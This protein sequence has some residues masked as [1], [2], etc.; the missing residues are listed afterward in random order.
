MLS[1]KVPKSPITSED[2]LLA[3]ITLRS[4]DGIGNRRIMELVEAFEK[5]TD[6]FKAPAREIENVL[7]PKSVRKDIVFDVSRQRYSSL[8]IGKSISSLK[9]DFSVARKVLDDLSKCD[10]RVI[11]YW[12]EEYLHRL[13]TI[14]DTPVLLYAA[15]VPSKL[16][17]YSIAIVGTRTPSDYSKLI[18][19][20]I[21]HSLAKQGI[22]VVS[23]MAMGIDS[24]A[25]E[26][27]LSAGGRT[28]GVLGTGIDI[29]YPSSNKRIFELVKKQGLLLSEYPPKT[30]PETYHFPQRNRIISGISIAVI[31][32]EAGSKSGALITARHAISQD[33]KLFAVP[34]LPDA[35]RS[36]G[37]NRLIKDGIAIMVENAEDVIENLRDKLAPVLNVSA[38]ITLPQ[39]AE[40]ERTIYDHLENGPLTVDELIEKSGMS[41]V[42][43]QRAITSMQLKNIIRKQQGGIVGRV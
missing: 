10:G 34:G 31:I 30:T 4:I 22:T 42:V 37:V 1:A 41:V 36:K 28:I 7:S 29:T 39:M 23:G 11:T 26:G 24:Q 32:V 13:R 21:A 3:L 12:D 25:H 27:A 35:T 43:I 38:A 33:R 17:D 6:V 40:S 2:E 9:S 5:P 15:G 14:Q 19:N 8:A 18:S 20:K 16:Y